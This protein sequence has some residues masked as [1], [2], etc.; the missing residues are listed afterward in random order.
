MWTPLT[1]RLA[2]ATLTCTLLAIGAWKTYAAGRSSGMAEVQAL[3]T[4]EQLKTAQATAQLLAQAQAK[5]R[6]LQ[7]QID[8]TRQK[9]RHEIDRLRAEHAADLDRLQHRPDRPAD[10][11]AGLPTDPGDGASQPGCTGA[12]LWR[13]DARF[14]IGEAARA[15]TLRLHLA[16]CQAAYD[17][18][19]AAQ[20]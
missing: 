5:E 3:W 4:A 1:L 14:L 13:S 16:A 20:P 15:D 11:S 9:K 6:T 10:G 2:A 8:T 19:R 17:A 12:E 7:T 18:V